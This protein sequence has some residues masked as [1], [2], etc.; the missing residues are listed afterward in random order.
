M[1]LNAKQ[2]KHLKESAILIHEDPLPNL[3]TLWL[4]WANDNLDNCQSKDATYVSVEYLLPV[5]WVLSNLYDCPPRVVFG[6]MKRELRKRVS[7]L[8]FYQ[9]DAL[10]FKQANLALG[11]IIKEMVPVTK[12]RKEMLN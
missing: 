4:D 9:M 11:E 12:A 3:T 2:L 6:L 7:L 5:I 10:N 8:G 1:E